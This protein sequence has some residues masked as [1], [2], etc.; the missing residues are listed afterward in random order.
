MKR[1]FMNSKTYNIIRNAIV[2]K[3]NIIAIYQGYLREMCPHIIGWKNGR[4][5]ALFYQFGGSSSDGPIISDSPNNWRCIP[6]DGLSDV[7]AKEG[8]WHTST[9]YA[10]PQSCVDE[11]DLKVEL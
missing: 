3:K 9:N 8:V 10:N 7:I 6:I 5:Q 1:K 11:I 2:N 4:E